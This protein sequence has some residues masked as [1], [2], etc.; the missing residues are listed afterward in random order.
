MKIKI[1]F[2]K[3]K[4]NSF[5][6]AGYIECV[7]KQRGYRKIQMSDIENEQYEAQDKHFSEKC[8]QH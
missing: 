6:N 7:K 8:I 3:T 2:Q 1:V 4:E 5:S